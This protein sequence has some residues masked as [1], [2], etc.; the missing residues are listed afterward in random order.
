METEQELYVLMKAAKEQQAAVELATQAMKTQRGEL[1][2]AIAQLKKMQ[3]SVAADAKLGAE[4]GL[5]GITTQANT[6]LTTEVNKAK[7]TIGEVAEDLR[8]RA[9]GKSFQ[10]VAGSVAFG[11]VLG[12]VLSWFMW[13]R[14]TRAAV[15]RLDTVSQAHERRLQELDQQQ[16]AQK[17]AT[18][19]PAPSHKPQPKQSTPSEPQQEP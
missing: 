10:W 11:L 8:V 7:E 17:P 13:A 12:V 15:E 14:D 5:S 3:A 19:H 9:W 18:P 6:A 4:R 2:D 1:Y 16:A